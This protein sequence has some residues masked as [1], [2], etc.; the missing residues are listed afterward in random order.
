[1][2]YEEVDV[3]YTVGK[4]HVEIRVRVWV[5]VRFGVGV[6]ARMRVISLQD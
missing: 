6:K 1:M 4:K 3:A 2:P 5:W